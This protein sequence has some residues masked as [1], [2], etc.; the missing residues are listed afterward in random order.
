ME[1]G[2]RSAGLGLRVV[3]SRISADLRFPPSPFC[4]LPISCRKCTSKYFFCFLYH[5]LLVLAH[6]LSNYYLQT[7]P[8]KYYTEIS[9]PRITTAPNRQ[10]ASLCLVANRRRVSMVAVSA[11]ERNAGLGRSLVP[12]ELMDILVTRAPRSLCSG[13]V[14]RRS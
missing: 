12:D 8:T 4:P 7:Y 3:Y 6:Q 11:L 2:G 5:V 1:T 13:Y 14:S 10:S 9:H